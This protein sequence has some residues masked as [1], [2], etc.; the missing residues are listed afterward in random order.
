MDDVFDEHQ[1]E[2]DSHVFLDNMES[3][4]LLVDARDVLGLGLIYSPLD[5]ALKHAGTGRTWF[6]MDG[7]EPRG[8]DWICDITNP[9][10]FPVCIHPNKVQRALGFA[11]FCRVV[12]LVIL[13]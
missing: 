5:H 12:L 3:H 11:K 6:R 8:K 1:Q 2:I 13:G 4:E 7:L 10:V 9:A